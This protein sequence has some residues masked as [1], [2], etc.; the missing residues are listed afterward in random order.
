MIVDP[1]IM[2][3][4]DLCVLLG[5]TQKELLEGLSME[6]FIEWMAYKEIKPFGFDVENQRVGSI[7]AAVYNSAGKSY[8][9][10]VVWDDFFKPSWKEP[11][12]TKQPGSLQTF[13]G[14]LKGLA[15]NPG[16]FKNTKDAQPGKV[17]SEMKAESLG[18]GAPKKDKDSK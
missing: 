11:Q 5:K 10:D 4:M 2:L 18:I 16:G 8:K 14:M 15:K 7:C 6:D 17:K 3:K 9:K 12:Q 13:I 1:K